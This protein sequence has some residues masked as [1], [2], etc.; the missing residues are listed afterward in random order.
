M[1]NNEHIFIMKDFS[2]L[3]NI[4]YNNMRP[5]RGKILISQPFMA[6]GCFSRSVILIT[7]Y[8]KDG[9]IGFILNKWLQITFDDI[10]EDFPCGESQLSIGGPVQANTLHYLHTFDNI[11]GAIEIVKGIYWGGNIDVVRKLLAVSIMKPEEIR[12]FIGYSGWIAG[13]LDDELK[14]NSWLVGDIR[15][16]QIINPSRNLW[17]DVV[18]SMGKKYQHWTNLPEN[19]SLN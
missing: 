18:K 4:T 14:S 13:Q 2:D 12:F 11:P 5:Q 9:T 10:I 17:Q 7:E 15:P 6:D 19:P 3:F 8:S 1:A 16:S